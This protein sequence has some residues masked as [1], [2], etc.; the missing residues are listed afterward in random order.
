[1]TSL[2]SM[3]LTAVVSCAVAT[4]ASAQTPRTAS[5][6]GSTWAY[7]LLLGGGSGPTQFGLSDEY[8]GNSEA[9][10]SIVSRDGRA[11]SENDR[12]LAIGLARSLCEDQGLQFNSQS[13]G[14]W[15]RNGMLGFHGAC[16]QW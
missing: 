4:G 13:R 8:D 14:N 16:T 7:Y 6:G 15:L 10:I 9:V 11:L 5:Y 2:K 12:T 3:F 1:M